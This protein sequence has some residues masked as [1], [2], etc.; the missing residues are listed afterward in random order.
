MPHAPDP[1]DTR[2]DQSAED[3]APAGAHAAQAAAPRATSPRRLGLT[4]LA[5]LAFGTL[6]LRAAGKPLLPVPGAKPAP[7]AAATPPPAAPHLVRADGS[8][9][10]LGVTLDRS[11]VAVGGDGLVRMELAIKADESSSDKAAARVDSDFVVVLDRSGSMSGDR[12]EHARG[13]VLALLDQLAQGDRF[14]L[15]VYDDAAQIAIPLAHADEAVKARWRALVSGIEPG[16]STNMSDGLDQGLALLGEGRRA[17]RPGRLILLSD[18]HANTGD[19]TPE[20]LRARGLRAAREELVLSTVG[21]GEGFNEYL[22]TAIADA[23]T[24]NYH[25]L[26][27]GTQLAGIFERELSSTRETVASGLAVRLAP[28]PGVQIVDAAGYPL[29]H[30]AGAASFKV[31]ALFAGQ[32]RRV[33]VTLRVPATSTGTQPLGAVEL[34]YSEAGARKALA[35]AEP[36]AVARVADAKAAL[37]AI[38][39]RAWERAVVQ[40]EWGRVQEQVARD[41]HEGKRDQ[42][43]RRLGDYQAHNARLNAEIGSAA[44]S[45]SLAQS[46]A[47]K[48]TVRDSFEG[49]DQHHK[50]N[51][52]S[53][54]QLSKGRK[55]RRVGS[56]REAK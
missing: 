8:A 52:F 33:W 21:I 25:Y 38:D 3:P 24:G 23:G 17:G 6:A 36:L 4:I 42:A 16:A 30:A 32:E 46:E 18:G 2:P 44:V 12:I 53:K 48:S 28:A 7:H 45:A 40:E 54:Q 34:A 14:A 51:V 31:G 37:A 5:A 27:D 15:V 9:L 41:V 49:A 11:A 13:A 47:L 43:L 1:H 35:I 20:G 50:Q 55:D 29:E 22:M 56:Y 10:S 19:A 26:A 39:A